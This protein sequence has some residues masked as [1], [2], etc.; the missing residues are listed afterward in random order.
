MHNIVP[1]EVV[2][3][4]TE[5]IQTKIIVIH[6]QHFKRSGLLEYCSNVYTI[7]PRMVLFYV[8]C[9]LAQSRLYTIIMVVTNV[10]ERLESFLDLNVIQQESVQNVMVCVQLKGNLRSLSGLLEY[11]FI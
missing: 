5:H 8:N 6:Q 9:C 11:L 3:C 7:A 2:R 10:F 1:L 4:V